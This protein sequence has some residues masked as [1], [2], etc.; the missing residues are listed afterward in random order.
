MNK[1]KIGLSLLTVL[2][3]VVTLPGAARAAKRQKKEA[4]S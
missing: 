1:R 4:V 2:M 3:L